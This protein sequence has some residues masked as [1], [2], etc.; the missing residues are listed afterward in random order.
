MNLIAKY[1]IKIKT[2]WDRAVRI[3]FVHLLTSNMLTRILAFMMVIGLA[4]FLSPSDVGRINIMMSVSAVLVT[5]ANF[6]TTT[7]VLK[8]C[9][10]NIAES[11]ILGYFVQG[12]ILNVITSLLTYIV[13]VGIV[14]SKVITKDNTLIF[15]FPWFLVS[16]TTTTMYTYFFAYMQARQKIE[17]VSKL[18]GSLKSFQF[19]AVIVFAF[20][21]GLK[22]F[23]IAYVASDL[24]SLAIYL[25]FLR[26]ITGKFRVKVTSQR[27]KE[28]FHLSK[29]GAFA[30]QLGRLVQSLDSII[31]SVLGVNLAGIGF[32]SVAQYFV[33]GG[34]QITYSLTQVAMPRLSFK[35]NEYPVWRRAYDEYEKTFK[36]VSIATAMALAIAGPVIIFLFLKPAYRVSIIYLLILL[37]GFGTR[38]YA[39]AR[40]IGTWSLGR[41]DYN[42]YSSLFVSIINAILNITMITLFGVLGAACG[43]SIAYLFGVPIFNLYFNKEVDRRKQALTLPSLQDQTAG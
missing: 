7:S 41:L 26:K 29:Y 40:S 27:F 18:Q 23:V 15:Y 30:N 3:G 33:L 31:M 16:N 8:L 12:T 28:V 14:L 24:L 43:T 13:A 11:D 38:S 1:K 4:W 19:L 34:N 9:S 21:W 2:Y 42:F 6:G 37:I 5:I 20:F 10:E 39:T 25:I 36:R 22:G 35:S 32:Y 17:L